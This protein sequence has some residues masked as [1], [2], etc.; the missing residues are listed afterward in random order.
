MAKPPR[1]IADWTAQEWEAVSQ[2]MHEA[3]Q[4]IDDSMAAIIDD[5]VQLGERG[6]TLPVRQYP[7]FAPRVVRAVPASHTDDVFV[8]IYSREGGVEFDA[9]AS[10]LLGRPD[11]RRWKPLLEQCIGAYRRRDYLITVPSLLAVYE[12]ALAAVVDKPHETKPRSLASDELEEA[13]RNLERLPWASIKAFTNAVFARSTFAGDRPNLLNRHWV[14]HGRDLPAFSRADC[15]RLFQAIHTVGSV[16][17]LKRQDKYEWIRDTVLRGYLRQCD[18]GE[19][20]QGSTVS[21][22]AT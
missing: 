18:K 9:V 22:A 8:W 13:E 10:D 16:R 5:A 2:A 19:P 3:T 7:D 20:T 11:L 6:W 21:D 4:A 1:T 14:L 15:L 17:L 12:G